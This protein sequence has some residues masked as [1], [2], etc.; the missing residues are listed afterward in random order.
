MKTR[1]SSL[2]LAIALALPGFVVAQSSEELQE[3][4]EQVAALNARI[5]E[6]ERRNRESEQSSQPEQQQAAAKPAEPSSESAP[7][8]AQAKPTW[9]DRIAMKG[10]FRYRFEGIDEEGLKN[11][12]RQRIRARLT[13]DAKVNDT[14]KVGIQLATGGSNPRSTN[15]TLDGDGSAKDIT[16]RQAYVNWKP[17]SELSLTA[18]KMPQP[19]SRDPI[20]Y[21]YDSDYMPEGMAVR[22]DAPAG[23]YG[24]GYWMQIDERGGDQDTSLWGGE[25]GYKNKLFYASLGYQDFEDIEGFNPCY[26]GNCNG[27]TVDANGRLVNDFNIARVRAGATL[28][29]FN[30][31]ASWARNGDADED[32]AQSYGVVYGKVKD[33]GTWSIA[34]I[35]QDME[36]DA[37]YGGMIDATF[38]AGRTAHDGYALKGTYALS[39]NWETSFLWVDTDIDKLGNKRDYQRYQFDLLWKF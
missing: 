33:P 23:F 28:A 10:D 24:T 2:A 22:F 11:R 25:V 20:D 15:E 19:W 4:K 17:M 32:T 13:L 9:A 35:Y 21:F 26:N 29:G 38:A 30:I 34:A 36:K 6:L 12:N 37:L 31:F 14:T 18:G 39:K 16:L 7:E 8:P 27:N 5:A 3:L 1:I